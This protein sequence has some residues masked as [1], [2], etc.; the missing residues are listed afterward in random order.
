MQYNGSD[1]QHVCRKY[2]TKLLSLV[3]RKS[4][5]AW[6]VLLWILAALQLRPHYLPH[7]YLLNR[8]RPSSLVVVALAGLHRLVSAGHRKP[9]PHRRCGDSKAAEECSRAQKYGR[10]SR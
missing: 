8:P 2:V 5:D 4:D 9:P 7:R 6:H 3:L 1:E 10:E